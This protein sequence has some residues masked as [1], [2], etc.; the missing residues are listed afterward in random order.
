MAGRENRTKEALYC[1]KRVVEGLGGLPDVQATAALAGSG[2]MAQRRLSLT[3]SVA[4][5]KG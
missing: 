3:N 5:W 2:R 4:T 1:L